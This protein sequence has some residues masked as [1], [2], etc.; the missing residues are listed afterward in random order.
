MCWKTGYMIE[1]SIT[2]NTGKNVNT[3]ALLDVVL[4]TDVDTKKCKENF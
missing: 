2:V 3:I 4:E 1:L